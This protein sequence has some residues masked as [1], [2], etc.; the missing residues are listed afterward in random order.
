[1]ET[2]GVWEN[3]GLPEDREGALVLGQCSRVISC[4]EVAFLAPLGNENQSSLVSKLQGPLLWEA[5]PLV[6]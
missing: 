3:T 6:G 4:P 5:L 2:R 1:M